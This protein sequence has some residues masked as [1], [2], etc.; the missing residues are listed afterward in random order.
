MLIL[1]RDILLILKQNALTYGIAPRA[2]ITANG[3]GLGGNYCPY[4]R[5]SANG[6]TFLVLDGAQLT[7]NIPS[8][9]SHLNNDVYNDYFV[10]QYSEEQW[11][12]SLKSSVHVTVTGIGAQ[13]PH[14]LAGGPYTIRS[15]H[16]RS[17]MMPYGAYVSEAGAWWE[18]MKAD[19]N[20]AEWMATDGFLTASNYETQ[21]RWERTG[22]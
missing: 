14:G 3:V 12:E 11:P 5:N 22:S 16:N 6:Y 8:S 21:R 19:G 13:A 10:M 2:K 20:E 4:G 1:L 9:P 7:I 18:A 15:D 17:F